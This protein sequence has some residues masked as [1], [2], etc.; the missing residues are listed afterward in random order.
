MTVFR[1]FSRL[2]VKGSHVVKGIQLDGLRKI[3]EPKKLA[4]EYLSHGVDEIILVDVVASL[5]NRPG[6]NSLIS[7]IASELRIPITALGGVRNIENAREVFEFGAD[8]VAINSA[9][10]LNPKLFGQISDIYGS[11]SVV[12][13]IEAKR[14]NNTDTWVC[15]TENGRNEANVD[16][17]NW[18]ESL[19]SIGVG[20]VIVTSVDQD[21]TNRG[22]DLELCKKIRYLTDLPVIYSGG[23]RDEEDALDIAKIGLD[24]IAIASSLHY[25]RLNVDAMK[26][27]L[28]KENIFIRTL[29]EN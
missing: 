18:V 22:P 23:I 13:S 6:L 5:Y 1:I 10:I 25:G 11:Q 24:G 9:G 26:K 21:G 29:D 27:K 20:E 7:E 8:K 28:I 12:C 16:M 4:G 19:E 2:D 15:M 17:S 14:L 3:G